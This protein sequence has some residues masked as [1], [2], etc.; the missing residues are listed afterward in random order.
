MSG[1]RGATS[2]DGGD[3]TI[4]VGEG[5]TLGTNAPGDLILDLGTRVTAGSTGKLKIR[6]NGAVVA[7]FYETSAAFY[8]EPQKATAISTAQSFTISAANPYIQ[9]ISTGAGVAFYGSL[10]FYGFTFAEFAGQVCSDTNDV[11]FAA[12]L[13]LNLNLS[14]HHRIGALTANITTLDASNLRDGSIHTVMVTQ[15]VT[16]GWTV[17]F[18]AKFKFGTTFT[19]TVDTAANAVTIWTFL[20]DGTNLRCISK[21]V[22]LT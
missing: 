1:Q 17:S 19:S 8:W 10:D 4:A 15:N 21:E 9:N 5:G 6:A 18:A 22:G 2:N 12:S 7:D 16:G 20:C 13:T 14:N 11:A 3:I